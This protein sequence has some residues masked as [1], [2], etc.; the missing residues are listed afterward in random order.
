MYYLCLFNEHITHLQSILFAASMYSQDFEVKKAPDHSGLRIAAM[1]SVEVCLSLPLCIRCPPLN[2]H[3]D[4][5][6]P[7]CNICSPPKMCN[8]CS[9]PNV[10]HMFPSQCATYVPLPTTSLFWGWDVWAI[11]FMQVSTPEPLTQVLQPPSPK[12]SNPSPTSNQSILT[13]SKIHTQ[14]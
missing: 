10:Q 6:L 13:P 2:V 7:M 11:L 8:I 3:S 12:Y 4:A 1:T 5:H 14:P 9:P